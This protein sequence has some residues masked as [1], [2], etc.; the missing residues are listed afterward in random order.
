MVFLSASP[1]G[2]RQEA[3]LFPLSKTVHARHW[4]SPQPYFAPVSWKSS[5]KTSSKGRSA[6]VLTV[7]DLPLMVKEIVEFIA[8]GIRIIL[9]LQ[10]ELVYWFSSGGQRQGS[11]I[12]CRFINIQVQSGII[13]VTSSDFP[14]CKKLLQG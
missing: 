9:A 6:S 8:L 5:R 14:V 4:P 1:T 7:R 3:T 12:I 2:V 13:H 10:S 11:F